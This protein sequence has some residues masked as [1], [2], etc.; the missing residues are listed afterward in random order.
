M[1]HY[2]DKSD[3]EVQRLLP[4]LEVGIIKGHGCIFKGDLLSLKKKNASFHLLGV[5]FNFLK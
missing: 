3:L 2:T 4:K 1:D 5:T